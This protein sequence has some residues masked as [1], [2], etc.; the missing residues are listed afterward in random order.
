MVHDG[1][2]P[3]IAGRRVAANVRWGQPDGVLELYQMGSEGPQWWTDYPDAGA[4]PARA[5]A[6][7]PAATCQQHLPEGDRALRRRRG[8]SR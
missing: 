8:V 1:A 2:W 5:A 4:Q 3:N 7:S 6:S